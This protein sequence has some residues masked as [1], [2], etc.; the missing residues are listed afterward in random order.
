MSKPQTQSIVVEY[1]F[2]KKPATVW[3]ALTE[4]AL[5]AQWLM[6]NDFRP[7]VGHKFNFRA[8]PV[9][10]WDGVVHCEV[11]EC[12]APTRL[13]YAWRGGSDALQGYG[14]RLDTTVTWTLSADGAGTLLRM[15][16]AGFTA[17]DHFSFTNMGGGWRGPI[18]Q[19]IAQVVDQL[20]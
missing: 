20:D 13:V 3:R 1:R 19:R 2:A 10:G 11:L 4:P 18:A 6:A 16:H 15:E 12:D 7:V 9:P 5:I 14:H 8:Q 17:D